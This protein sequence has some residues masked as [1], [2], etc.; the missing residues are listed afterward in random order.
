MIAIFG[1]GGL[2]TSLKLRLSR[3]GIQSSRAEENLALLK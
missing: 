2:T 3:E 1:A